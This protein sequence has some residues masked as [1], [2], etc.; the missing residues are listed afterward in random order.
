MYCYPV[1]TSCATERSSF[2]RFKSK[3]LFLLHIVHGPGEPKQGQSDEL[4]TLNM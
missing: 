3:F 4:K 1:L 2:H